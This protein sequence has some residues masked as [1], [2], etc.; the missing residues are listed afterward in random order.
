MWNLIRPS[1]SSSVGGLTIEMAPRTGQPH[2][3]APLGSRKKKAKLSLMT[4][5]VVLAWLVTIRFVSLDKGGGSD[6]GLPQLNSKNAGSAI[7]GTAIEKLDKPSPAAVS[8]ANAQQPSGIAHSDERG[9]L[10]DLSPAM[11]AQDTERLNGPFTTE[12][13]DKEAE[14]SESMRDVNVRA[15]LDS[16]TTGEERKK[17]VLVHPVM[18]DRRTRHLNSGDSI[19]SLWGAVQRGSLA[20][21]RALAERFALGDGVAMNCDQA[22][23]LLKAAANRGSRE[24]QLRLDELETEGCR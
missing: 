4:A 2:V 1:R 20:A 21:G 19:E 5:A 3:Y 15:S 16:T 9:E 14:S 11:Q 8:P 10:G 23:V 17:S 6:S 22:K 24:A 18:R 13:R 12:I 7:K